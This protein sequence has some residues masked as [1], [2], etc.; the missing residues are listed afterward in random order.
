VDEKGKMSYVV[1]GATGNV[2]RLGLKRSA[3]IPSEHTNAE[4]QKTAIWEGAHISG[5]YGARIS[6]SNIFSMKIYCDEP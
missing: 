6:I 1:T 5:I 3:D 2:I 4:S